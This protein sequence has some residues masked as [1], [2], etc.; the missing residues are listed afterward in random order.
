[1]NK[2]S[3]LY[4]SE[5]TNIL[6]FED[7]DMLFICGVSEEW[8]PCP[9]FECAAHNFMTEILGG[10]EPVGCYHRLELLD[11]S[12]YL[13]WQIAING[14]SQLP[15]RPILLPAHV[16]GGVWQ[17]FWQSGRPVLR[18]PSCSAGSVY[19]LIQL[20][21]FSFDPATSIM[22]SR[23]L[24]TTDASIWPPNVSLILI[25]PLSYVL[26]VI[27]AIQEAS[28]NPPNLNTMEEGQVPADCCLSW[29]AWW[30][31]LGVWAVHSWVCLVLP[32]NSETE[33]WLEWQ[34]FCWY[35]LIT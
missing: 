26:Y 6:T 34:A 4:C 10:L 16:D 28:M 25:Q 31:G 11:C 35:N 19:K 32:Y 1:M 13:R 33:R 24:V 9:V 22:E 15:F 30:R 29:H 3:A 21:N 17:Q 20:Y 14:S 18:T 2:G 8:L 12:A 27:F 23:P 5:Q 7:V